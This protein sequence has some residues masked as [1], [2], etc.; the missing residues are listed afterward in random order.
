MTDKII[1]VKRKGCKR[2]GRGK[3]RK[4]YSGGALEVGSVG[5]SEKAVALVSLLECL[6]EFNIRCF[7]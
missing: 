2:K 3:E 7:I 1:K 6:H 5:T 4:T